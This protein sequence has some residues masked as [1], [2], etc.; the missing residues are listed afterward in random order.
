MAPEHPR[1]AVKK[2]LWTPWRMP[3]IIGPKPAQCIFCAKARE[4]DDRTNFVL[5]RGQHC[6]VLL[7][8]YPYAAGHL[9]IAPYQHTGTV[10]ELPCQ[11]TTEMM[12]F[13]KRSLGILRRSHRAE[14]FNVGVNIGAPA[15]AGIADHVHMHVVPRWTG[16]SNFM[17]VLGDVRLIPEVL[18]D[19]YEKLLAAGFADSS[20]A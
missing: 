3:F 11:A 5:Q 4:R 9:M 6:F 13:V 8:A 18:H 17:P 1:A 12:E 16:D 20:S 14:S 7:N 10:E 19:T 2:R 15:G